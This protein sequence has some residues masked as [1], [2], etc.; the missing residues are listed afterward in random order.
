MAQNKQEIL[1]RIHQDVISNKI[2]QK[3]IASESGLSVSFISK[4]LKGEKTPSLK[5]LE[6]LS[7]ITGSTISY[8]MTGQ[9]VHLPLGKL[10]M[11]IDNC[12]EAGTIRKDGYVEP[13]IFEKLTLLLR[14]EI[15]EKLEKLDK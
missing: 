13:E 15:M 7:R 6:G 10:N 9:D 14:K 11:A 8:Y 5:F 1:M 12:I 4:I 2:K 3:D